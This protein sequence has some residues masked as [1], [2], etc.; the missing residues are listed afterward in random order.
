[1]EKLGLKFRQLKYRL[2]HDYFSIENVVLFFAILM[3][4]TWTYQSVVAMT[5]NW[6]LTEQL[7]TDRKNLELLEIEVETAELENEYYRSEE[8]QELQARKLLNKKLPGENMIYLPENSEEAKNKH[9]VMVAVEE[10][11][12]YLNF[13]K[14]LLFL[15]PSR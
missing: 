6:A 4:L 1:M 10:E 14:W 9:K 8:Y 15:F 2:K 7:S 3:C 5:R 11:K 12:E 13:E